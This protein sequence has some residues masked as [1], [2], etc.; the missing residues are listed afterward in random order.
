MLY[1]HFKRCQYKSKKCFQQTQQLGKHIIENRARRMCAKHKVLNHY[2]NLPICPFRI[3]IYIQVKMDWFTVSETNHNKAEWKK[4][5][6]HNTK[7]QNI[8]KR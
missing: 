7:Q 2:L 6:W 5:T 1:P 8:S 3:Y 4:Y